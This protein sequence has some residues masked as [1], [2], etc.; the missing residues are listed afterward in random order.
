M[1]R[2]TNLRSRLCTQVLCII[3]E[4]FSLCNT[5][6]LRPECQMSS[7]P[8]IRYRVSLKKLCKCESFA[9]FDVLV[10]RNDTLWRIERATE[11]LKLGQGYKYT[12]IRR[13]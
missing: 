9:Q 2:E 1:F 4:I 7:E 11:T 6:H 3:T 5:S 8:L 10:N 12:N 13:R